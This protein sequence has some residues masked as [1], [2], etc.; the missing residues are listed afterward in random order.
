[1]GLNKYVTPPRLAPFFGTGFG[2]TLFSD[3]SLFCDTLLCDIFALEIA[4]CGELTPCN[5]QLS[6]VT[7]SR[8]KRNIAGWPQ[9]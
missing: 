3:T 2:G 7:A 4:F 8:R 9:P 5:A 6:A 1:M